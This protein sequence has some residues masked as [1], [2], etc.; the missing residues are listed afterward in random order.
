MDSQEVC[1]AMPKAK[2]NID[3]EL[4]RRGS[5]MKCKR[6]GTLCRIFMSQLEEDPDEIMCGYCDHPP[7]CHEDLG[8]IIKSDIDATSASVCL[9]TVGNQFSPKSAT[10]VLEDDSTVSGEEVVTNKNPDDSILVIPTQ[11][12]KAQDCDGKTTHKRHKSED[13]DESF[14]TPF[15]RKQQREVEKMRDHYAKNTPSNFDVDYYMNNQKRASVFCSHCNEHVVLCDAKHNGLWNW[16]VHLKGTAHSNPGWR[17]QFA[18][19]A[20]A[21]ENENLVKRG[22]EVFSRPCYQTFKSHPKIRDN[23]Q[24]HI[25]KPGHIKKCAPSSKCGRMESFFGPKSASA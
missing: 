22:N 17:D 8:K 12:R 25:V 5:C 21:K 2:S 13:K 15:E 18:N 10:L 9:F 20:V 23:V 16:M 4:V 14:K 19:E 1:A 11:K 24:S 3:I 6:K 7:G